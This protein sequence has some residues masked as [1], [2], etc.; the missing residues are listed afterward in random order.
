MWLAPSEEIVNALL[1]NVMRLANLNMRNV[2]H[3][4][5]FAAQPSL[6]IQGSQEWMRCGVAKLRKQGPGREAIG[7]AW[8][9]SGM[10]SLKLIASSTAAV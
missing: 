1:Q 5:A 6:L 7:P 10:L 2:V 9:G 4:T 8:S 3:H